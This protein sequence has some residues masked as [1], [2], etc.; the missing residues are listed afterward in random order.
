MSGIA[1]PCKH[2]LYATRRTLAARECGAEPVIVIDYGLTGIGACKT[3]IAPVLLWAMET[4]RGEQPS[5][6][7]T[8]YPAW[9]Y[10]ELKHS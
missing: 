9:N 6:V 3:H 10:D 4:E 1:Y 8:V 2:L 7:A 5:H